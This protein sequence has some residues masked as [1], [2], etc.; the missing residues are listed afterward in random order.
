M[1]RFAAFVIGLVM[2][3]AGSAAA[4]TTSIDRHGTVLLDGRRIFPIVLAKGPE[5]DGLAEVAAAG[6]NF[7]KVGPAGAWNDAAIAETIAANR[8]AAANGLHARRTPSYPPR[9]STTA[10]C[11]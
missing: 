7:V 10:D 4:A 3:S 6:A 11:G 2:A 5:A 9:T 8:A 1:K